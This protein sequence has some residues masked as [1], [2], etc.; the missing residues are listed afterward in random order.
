M[1]KNFSKLLL[2]MSLALAGCSQAEDEP[3]VAPGAEETGKVA[4]NISR[5]E[6]SD[7]ADAGISDITVFVYHVE[8]KGTTLVSETTMPVGEGTLEMSFPLGENYQTF[9]VAN[10][11]SITGKE[12][13]ATVTLNLDPAAKNDVWATN[14]V[15]FASDKSYPEISLVFSRRVAAVNFAPAETDTELAAISDFDNINLTFTEVATAYQVQANKAVSTTYTVSAPASAGYKA[16]FHTFDTTGLGRGTLTIDYTK[17]G[18]SVRKSQ[19]LEC[20][21]YAAGKRISSIVPITDLSIA[22]ASRAFSPEIRWIVTD[23]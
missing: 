23:F 18:Q 10:A 1:I 21:T 2:C 15:R 16:S 5:A 14:V 12:T 4:I 6:A 19:P 17:G 13:L 22:D 20:D 3:T 11:A 9:A 7:F 8:R